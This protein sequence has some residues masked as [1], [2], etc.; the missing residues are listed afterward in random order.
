MIEGGEPGAGKVAISHTL[1]VCVPKAVE[2]TFVIDEVDQASAQTSNGWDIQLT[3]AHSLPEGLIQEPDSAINRRWCIVDAQREGTNRW[4]MGDVEGMGKAL[5]VAVHHDV[6]VTL[7]PVSHVL[8]A[9][10]P[11]LG[12]AEPCQ[13]LLER[14]CTSLVHGKLDELHAVTC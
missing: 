12:T 11:S 13:N 8:G 2:P 9:I 6:D 14:L 5:L 7:T 4:S 1:E 10:P 3:W